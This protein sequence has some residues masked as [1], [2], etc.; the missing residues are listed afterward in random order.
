MRFATLSRV[1][2]V[3]SLCLLRARLGRPRRAGRLVARQGALQESA[4]RIQ[5]RPA[6]GLERPADRAA[7]PRHAARPRRPEGETGLGPSPPRPDDA[8]PLRRLVPALEGRAQRGRTAGHERLDLRRELL[9][10]RLRRRLGAG[11]DARIPRPRPGLPRGQSRAEMVGRPGR[12][13]SPG[14]RRLRERHG[15]GQSRRGPARRR[16]TSWPPKCARRTR[17][18]TATGAT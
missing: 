2:G 10:L 3:A 6:L 14:R 18:G 13:L 4:A 5:H 9:S 8:L 7:N 11:A 15:Q 17:P 1:I 12:R 16:A